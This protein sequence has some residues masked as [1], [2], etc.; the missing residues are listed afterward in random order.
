MAHIL[1]RDRDRVR[2][3]GRGR[4]RKCKRYNHAKPAVHR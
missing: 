1:K 3:R 4:E 2:E